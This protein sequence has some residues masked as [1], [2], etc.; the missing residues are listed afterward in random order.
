V[1]FARPE[2]LL[3]LV[4]L[5]PGAIALFAR[6]ARQRREAL[7]LFLGNGRPSVVVGSSARTALLTL[8]LALVVVA[9]AGPRVGTDIAET[10]AGG[11]DLVVALDVS[12]SMAARDV[13]PD[14]LERARFAVARM[15]EAR[16][17][18]RLALVVFAGEA[19]LLS[20]LT[21]DGGAFRL[22]LDA[23]GPDIVG[24]AGSEPARALEVAASAF[25]PGE[26]TRPRAIL[27]VTDGE[28]PNVEDRDQDAELVSNALRREGIAVL[29]LGVGTAEGGTIPLPGGR[30]K[31]DGAGA[32]VNT[33]LDR[34]ALGRLAGEDVF[35]V[36]AESA[37]ALARRLDD[38]A[39][40]GGSIERVPT[41]AERYQWPLA[42]AL[43]GLI[44]ERLLAALAGAGANLRLPRRVPGP[45]VAEPPVVPTDSSTA[46][47]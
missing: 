12:A 25:D 35:D 5:V 9:L 43:A 23:A 7:S 26:S 11:L 33:R 18:D 38:I 14:R 28:N 45:T 17:T 19:A 31:R 39:G 16:P 24:S 13:P 44:L 10:R 29:A 30:I 27:L 37:Q 20:P 8:A 46:I 40:A 4:V 32:V 3:M 21:R 15:A 34:S 1:T 22:F 36:S 2:L 41:V 6:A 42:V 47:A